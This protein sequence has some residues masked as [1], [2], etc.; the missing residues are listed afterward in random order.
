MIPARSERIPRYLL[1]ALVV[2]GA[3]S[4][5]HFVHNAQYI[6][7][8]PNLPAWLTRSKVYLAW[9]AITSV[10][11]AGVLLLNSGFRLSGL[12][13]IAVYAALGFAGL[14]HYS[15]AAISAHSL[16]MNATIAFEVTA[17]A[18]LF[19]ISAAMFCIHASKMPRAAR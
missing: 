16:A 2:Y 1:A 14:D 9:L 7:E 8:Y 18:I 17:A 15:L 19:A 10:G 13:L 3:A 12:A 4:L 5:I 6:A 11:A